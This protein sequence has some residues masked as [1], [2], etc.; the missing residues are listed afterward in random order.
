MP[1]ILLIVGAVIV[2][3]ALALAFLP[4]N[5][6][7]AEVP[8]TPVVEQVRVID[9][10]DSALLENGTTNTDI[11]PS[12]TPSETIEEKIPDNTDTPSVPASTYED[13]TYTTE[14]SYKVPSSQMEPMTVKLTLVN[15][16]ISDVELEFEGVIGTSRLNQAK[17]VGAYEPL[18]IGK[19]IDTLNLSRVG[20]ASLTTKA[21][22]EAL[23]KIKA[24]ASS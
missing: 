1:A 17:F 2:V 24:D 5:K 8:A 7:E 15:D 12:E 6:K 4:S 19:D 14:I 21:F 13:G 23:I 11:I 18:V 3:G 10:N 22:N 9:R 20:G 16:I